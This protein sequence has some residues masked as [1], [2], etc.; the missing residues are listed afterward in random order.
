MA[1]IPENYL[2]PRE[3]WPE[4]TVPEEFADTP[5]RLNLADFLLDR[6]IREGRG[7]NVAIKFQDRVFTFSTTSSISSQTA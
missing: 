4:F 3:T 6:H 5:R 7:D 1:K 2:P